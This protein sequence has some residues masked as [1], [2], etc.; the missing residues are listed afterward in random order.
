MATSPSAFI[1]QFEEDE[2]EEVKTTFAQCYGSALAC[3]W[4][5]DPLDSAAAE[6]C[7]SFECEIEPERADLEPWIEEMKEEVL[8]ARVEEEVNI[9]QQQILDTFRSKRGNG[10]TFLQAAR[11]TGED[12]AYV[13]AVLNNAGRYELKPDQL[14]ALRQAHREEEKSKSYKAPL[15]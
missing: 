6:F 4:L 3:D 13:L 8:L 14:S 5:D 7:E 9:K 2:L 11:A 15:G 10:H 12:P 1:A